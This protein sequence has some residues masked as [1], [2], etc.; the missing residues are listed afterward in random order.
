MSA[1][2]KFS[3]DNQEFIKALRLK[4]NNFFEENNLSKHGGWRIWLKVV[5]QFAIYFVPYILMFTGV[6]TNPWLVFASWALMGFG[7][8]GIGLNIMH[9]ANHGAFSDN[10]KVNKIMG[11][12]MNILG[13][14]KEIWKIQHNVL[15][16]SYTNIDGADDDIDI[17]PILRF[18]PHRKLMKLH[19]FQFIYAWF[20]YGLLTLLRLFKSDFTQSVKFNKL[21]LV[22]DYKKLMIQIVSWKI[23]Y[24][25]YALVLPLIFI[26]A[27]PWLIIAGFLTM[28][29]IASFILSAIFQ[30]AH[31]MPTS[32]FPLPDEAGKI[33]NDWAL[34]QMSTTCN[35]SPRDPIFSWFVGGLNFQV[36]HHL[37]Q[38]IS[39]VHYRKLSKIV[40]ETAE[41]FKVPY[42]NSSTFVKAMWEHTKML[43]QLGNAS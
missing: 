17:A 5:F 33:H 6:I 31:I 41:E 18:S 40:K 34:H 2:H 13:A 9:D 20:L 7:M 22:K 11:Y 27:S 3:K 12:T 43:K 39:H 37:F 29:F 23:I 36:E 10:K 24:L 26:Q 30:T 16:H 35:Y 38:S 4:I 42:Y 8:A 28:H 14:N 21:G 19:R 1:K 15:H 32:E 25:V